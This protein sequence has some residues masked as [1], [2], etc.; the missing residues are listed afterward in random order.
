MNIYWNKG[1]ILILYAQMFFIKK[2][3]SD[4]AIVVVYID[5]LNII[6]TLGEIPKK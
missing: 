3:E 2:L 5:D 6:K 1:I 4:F